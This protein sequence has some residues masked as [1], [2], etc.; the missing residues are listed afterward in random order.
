M[1]GTQM[2]RRGIPLTAGEMELMSLL[3]KHGPQTLA[4]VHVRLGRPAAY[5][6]VQTRLNRLVEKQLA[7]RSDERPAH[8]RA[9]VHS[10]DV[11]ASHLDQL[12]ER[13]TRGTIVP[14]VAHLVGEHSLSREEIDEL[15]RLVDEAEL[16]LAREEQQ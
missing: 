16:R 9:A 7:R 6:T 11:G 15:K 2:K 5:T 14:L 1:K 8:Y 10:E 12:V 13:V 3:W 4:E